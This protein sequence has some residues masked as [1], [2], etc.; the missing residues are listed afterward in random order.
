MAANIKEK[1]TKYKQFMHAKDN[2]VSAL[3]KIIRYQSATIN[4]AQLVPNW[5]NLLPIKHDVEESKIQN[6]IL[7]TLLLENGALV[8]GENYANFER[9][10]LILS[11]ILQKKYLKDETGVK[12]ATLVK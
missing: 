10:V 8:L 6:E 9:V 2:A 3:G 12:L 4:P 1:K 11:E 7:T 5:L